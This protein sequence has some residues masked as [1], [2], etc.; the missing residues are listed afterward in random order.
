[1]A[2]TVEKTAEI[3]DATVD[4]GCACYP[5]RTKIMTALLKA[6][7]AIAPVT[8]NATNPHFKSKYATLEAVLDACLEPLHAAG[9]VSTLEPTYRGLVGRLTHAASGEH[10]ECFVPIPEQDNAQ[11]Y[12]SWLT[13]AKRYALVSMLCIPQEDDDGNQAAR[14]APPRGNAPAKSPAMRGG[15]QLAEIHR[16]EAK[17]EAATLDELVENKGAFEQYIVGWGAEGDKLRKKREDLIRKKSVD[18]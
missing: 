15:V 3:F 5:N 10:M 7:K 9:I 18:H 1:M 14:P 4:N 13:Y 11:K 17:L 2:V 16:V 6:Q 12:G 8:K